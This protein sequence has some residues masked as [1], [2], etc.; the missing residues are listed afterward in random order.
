MSA[1]SVTPVILRHHILQDG[2][3]PVKIRVT[4]DRKSRYIPTTTKA[5]KSEYDKDLHLK[6]TVITRLTPMLKNIDEI[7]SSRM[8]QEWEIMDIGEV[9]RCIEEGLAPDKKFT[10]DFFKWGESFASTRP[11]YSAANYRTAL[12]SFSRFL[13]KKEL[14]ISQVTS[15][16]M[17]RYEAYL[18][19]RH[20][21]NAR[22]V[23]L[24]TSAI[25]AI[26]GEARKIYNDNES[27]NI[28]ILNPF[29][30]Y[31][32]P[33]Q[34][35]AR[36]FALKPEVIQK[37]ID[38]REH[39]GELH[40]LA[41]DI[42]LLSFVTMG[43]N[44]PD[45]YEAEMHEDGI[46]YYRMKVRDRR[47]DKGEMLIRLEPVCSK[48]INDMKDPSGKRAFKL[49]HQYT[50]YKSIADKANDRLKEVAVAIGEKPFTIKAARHTWPSIAFSLGIHKSLI[51]DCLCHVDPDMIVTDIYIK[52]DWSVLWEANKKVLEQFDWK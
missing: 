3:C 31:K 39:L 22:A 50:A 40:K 14:D 9:V 25:G 33:K 27:G 34:N 30:F 35:Q 16:L 36:K 52:K 41:V 43:T 32:P 10:L 44:V 7:L 4:H 8:V 38:I 29:E 46:H 12:S 24:Y 5:L 45:L 19:E 15:S 6:S 1:P 17:R 18:M 51:N 20:G 48:L 47:P 13:E 23:S 28:K 26:H 49:Y 37:L 2:S 21:K 11:K 42:F